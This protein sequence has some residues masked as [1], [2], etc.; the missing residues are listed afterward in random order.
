M[1]EKTEEERRTEDRLVHLNI[2]GEVK[3]SG[4]RRFTSLQPAV[5]PRGDFSPSCA[6]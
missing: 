2:M 1:K 3:R 4:A 6:L 5:L